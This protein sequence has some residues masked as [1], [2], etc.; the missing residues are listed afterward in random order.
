MVL[1]VPLVQVWGYEFIG[2]LNVGWGMFVFE[3]GPKLG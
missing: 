3:K 2:F 1:R